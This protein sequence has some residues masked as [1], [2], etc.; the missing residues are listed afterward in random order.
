MKKSE[1]Q[2]IIESLEEDYADKD[3]DNLD[4]EEIYDM[5][6]ELDICDN[7]FEIDDEVLE[8]VQQGWLKLREESH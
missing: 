3:I 6:I 2:N 8:K 4:P 1:I 7:V 5:I